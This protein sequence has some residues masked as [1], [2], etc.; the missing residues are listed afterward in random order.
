MQQIKH[1][2]QS[3][4]EEGWAGDD[5]DVAERCYSLPVQI[6]H[7]IICPPAATNHSMIIVIRVVM[8]MM[9]ISHPRTTTTW[10]VIA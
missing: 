4:G 1:V 10:W 8:N 9:T 3:R 2:V 7:A 6:Q 5:N